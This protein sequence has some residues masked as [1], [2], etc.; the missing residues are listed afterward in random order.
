[1][2]EERD[3]ESDIRGGGLFFGFDADL[4]DLLF[5]VLQL[6][7]EHFL[8]S[9]NLEIDISEIFASLFHDSLPMALLNGWVLEHLNQRERFFET[10]NSLLQLLEGWH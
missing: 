6:E 2:K 5:V 10:S 7:L 9:K 8:E 1:M 3:E 4:G